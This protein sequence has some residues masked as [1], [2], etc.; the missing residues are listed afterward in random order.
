MVVGAPT[1]DVVYQV[2]KSC[3]IADRG[4]GAPIA[5]PLVAACTWAGAKSDRKKHRETLAIL[6]AVAFL[7]TPVARL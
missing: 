7:F 3:A 2:A 6:N 4:D 1:G 5:A